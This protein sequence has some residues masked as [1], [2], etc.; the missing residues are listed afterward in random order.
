MRTE[1]WKRDDGWTVTVV[2]NAN[3][4]V[5]TDHI[6]TTN[7]AVPF[8]LTYEYMVRVLQAHG[9]VLEKAS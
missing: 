2:V 8:P 6:P 9:Y 5:S 4:V 7:W 1:L 3:G